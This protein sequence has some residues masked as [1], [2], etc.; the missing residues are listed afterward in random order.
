MPSCVI[1]DDYQNVALAM[2]DWSGVQERVSIRVSD[3]HLKGQDLVALLTDAE[4][5]VM[6]RERTPFD[7]A[8]FAALPRLKL[9]VTTGMRN[10]SID[11]TAAAK[12]GV[13]VCGTPSAPGTTAELTWG[14]IHAL[15]RA[16]PAENAHF[17]AG[18]PWQTSVGRDL[19]GTTLGIVGLGNLGQRVA[20]VGAAFEMRVLGW[21][22]SLTE[23]TARSVGAGRAASLHDLL[24][25][26]DIVS[27][28]IPL[29]AATRG[30][31]G[32]AELALMKP[33]A[34]IINSSRGPIIDEA[35]L[36]EALETGRI[37]GAGLDVF[38]EEPLPGDHPL[39]RLPNVI[40]TPHLGYVTQANYRA[41][42]EG[43]VED[44]AAWLDGTPVRVM[45]G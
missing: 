2:A 33:E 11:F 21:S 37:A 40:A 1:L 26:S 28:H 4:I 6:M 13:T 29:N 24:R 39:R 23:E 14:L 27:I 17:H 36:V 42:F 9:L 5:V 22:R 31:I 12:H 19:R 8:L 43:V 20:R 25:E 16:I 32:P 3:R 45:T 35:A 7:A 34:L 18:G 30:L 44:I 15:T 38:D 41:Y 10:A